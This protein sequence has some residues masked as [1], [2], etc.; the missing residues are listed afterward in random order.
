MKKI[1]FAVATIVCFSGCLKSGEE[2]TCNYD[3]CAY[4][5]PAA[6][7]KMVEDY[8]AASS[9]VATKHCSGL[10]YRIDNPGTGK[11][12]SNCSEVSVTY[13]GKLTN[14]NTFDQTSTP[15]TFYLS[16]LIA[17]WQ[18]ALP[19]IKEGGRIYLYLPPS[20][21][22]GSQST[23]SIPA[24]SVLIFKIDLVAVR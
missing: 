23:G 22:Y 5:A 15:V 9:T 3:A 10:Y 19:L 2:T 20:L 14:G 11:V 4:V 13:E 1:L 7:V 6:E 17:G 24:N 21:G 8:L 16:Q 12:P 18:N